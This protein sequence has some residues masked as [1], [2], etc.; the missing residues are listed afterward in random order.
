M[1][2]SGQPQKSQ[3]CWRCPSAGTSTSAP[4]SGPSPR[5][6]RQCSAPRGIA[7]GC[8][9]APRPTSCSGEGRGLETV[10]RESIRRAMQCH[11]A[12]SHSHGP[13]MLHL[14]LPPAPAPA[15]RHPRCPRRSS[16]SHPSCSAQFSIGPENHHSLSQALVLN[17]QFI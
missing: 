9:S 14:P 16:R 12:T 11:P 5:P 4:Q 13:A 15:P 2:K 7:G 8:P 6:R 17:Q 1:F 3:I 10:H